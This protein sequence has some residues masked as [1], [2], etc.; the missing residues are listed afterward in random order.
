MRPHRPPVIDEPGLL[1]DLRSRSRGR[2]AA[3]PRRLWR[4][5]LV[6]SGFL[7]ACGLFG[8]VG[9]EG[10]THPGS[11]RPESAQGD[12]R[13]HPT[14]EVRGVVL[15]E[16]GQPL[17][18]VRVEI[19]LED[20]LRSA[21][22]TTEDGH[23]ALRR[24][25]GDG[26]V[27]LR[28]ERLGYAPR[29]VVL[30]PQLLPG[31]PMI[32]RLEPA[33]LPLPGLRVEVEGGVCP[34][35]SHP[36]G[37]VLWEAMA[38]RHPNGLDTLGAV[39]YTLVRVDT[40]ATTGRAEEGPLQAG[41]RGFS[42]RL[43]TQ[44]ERR[45]ERD[46]YAFPVRRTDLEGSFDAWSYAPLEADFASHFGTPAF[47]RH[48]TLR[49]PAPLPTGGWS[50]GFCGANTDRPSIEGTLALS[51]DTLLLRADWR[52]RTPEPDEEAGGWTRF[53]EVGPEERP[54]LLLPLESVTW[55]TLRGGDIQRRS[56]WY[57]GW[58][59]T[60]GDSIPFLPE[61]PE[62]IPS[63]PPRPVDPPSRRR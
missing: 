6:W 11:D 36:E 54:P 42:G 26:V 4:H 18:G 22:V 61:R 25:E 52:F 30:T 49:R 12:A 35:R 23:F 19:L 37:I 9:L 10:R 1:A 7:L 5:H 20:R 60:P 31:E 32:L 2:P 33:P 45:L 63:A 16:R 57:E 14:D 62:A 15:D 24:P 43:R 50:L 27:T 44:W 17:V 13:A 56:Q 59:V 40:L 58:T 41:Q 51:P 34:S 39:S 38:R 8:W 48:L 46:G 53:P 3:R 47:P 28:A 21:T 55:R 29:V